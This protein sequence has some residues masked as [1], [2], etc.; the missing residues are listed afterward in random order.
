MESE[1][2]QEP[3]PQ[4][5]GQP[6]VAEGGGQD[7]GREQRDDR[8]EYIAASLPA[9]TA[10]RV[11]LTDPQVPEVVV[12]QRRRRAE[13][14]DLVDHEE[15]GPP[16]LAQPLRDRVVERVR[17]L[18][19]VDHQNDHVGFLDGHHHLLADEPVHRLV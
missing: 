5:H 2:H 7:A 3:E 15:H 18:A 11:W 10:D 16:R 8:V 1:G 12:L 6:Q 13:V 4:E 9:Q 19:P 17:A 14:V